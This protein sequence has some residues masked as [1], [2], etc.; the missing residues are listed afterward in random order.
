M[1]KLQ[2]ERKKGQESPLETQFETI[3]ETEMS[4][5]NYKNLNHEFSKPYLYL[6]TENNVNIQR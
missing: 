5:F 2:K 4:K 1:K 3:I 6:Q